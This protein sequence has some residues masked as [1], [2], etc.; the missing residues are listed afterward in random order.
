MPLPWLHALPWMCAS[1]SAV[2]D[3]PDGGS[4]TVHYFFLRSA[5]PTLARC[6]TNLYS[7]C[8]LLLSFVPCPSTTVVSRS[9]TKSHKHTRGQHAHRL[10]DR[11]SCRTYA[12]RVSACLARDVT[13]LTALQL[14]GLLEVLMGSTPSANTSRSSPKFSLG[15]L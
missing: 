7:S 12:I 15:H 1:C 9:S 10:L 13:G 3:A 4:E 11:S 14:E 6:R 8:R 2:P 5:F